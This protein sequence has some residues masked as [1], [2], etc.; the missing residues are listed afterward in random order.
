MR[1][2]HLLVRAFFCAWHAV[3]SM[4]EGVNKFGDFKKQERRHGGRIPG[5]G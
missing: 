3:N 1:P 2:D 5:I 4:E